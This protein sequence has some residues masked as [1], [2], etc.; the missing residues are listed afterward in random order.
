[1][2]RALQQS[3]DYIDPTAETVINATPYVLNAV[4]SGGRA[5]VAR[6]DAA[7]SAI[8][9]RLATAAGLYLAA[10]RDTVGG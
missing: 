8:K 3:H 6:P 5:N 9:G 2:D 1:M 4:D 7:V 10:Q